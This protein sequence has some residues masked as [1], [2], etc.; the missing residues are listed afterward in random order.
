MGGKMTTLQHSRSRSQFRAAARFQLGAS[1]RQGVIALTAGF[2]LA[3]AVMAGPNGSGATSGSALSSTGPVRPTGCAGNQPPVAMAG[4]DRTESASVELAF[5]GGNSHDPNGSII[6][7][8]WDFGDGATS[9][10]AV[11]YHAFEDG[12]D[13]EVTLVVTDNCGAV[14]S[15]SLIVSIPIGVA[16]DSSC[17]N[18]ITPTA[19]AGSNQQGSTGVAVTLNGSASYDPDGA[20]TSYWWNYGD[21]QFTGW[22]P[23]AIIT[24]TYANA[25]TY[26]V[27]LWARDNCLV[28]SPSD[29]ITVTISSNNA[30]SGNTPPT[31][32]AGSDASVLVNQSISFNGSGST[33][34]GGSISSYSWNF[35]DGTT[36]S[37][38]AATKSYAAAGTYTV[39]LTVTDNCGA[40]SSDTASVSVSAGGGGSCSNNQTPTA[41]AGSD[42]SNSPGA[43]VTLSGTGST[44]PNNNITEYWWNFGDGQYTNWQPLATVSH[45]YASAG[46]FSARLWV[47]DAC[48]AMSASDTAII[49][50]SSGGG[51]NPCA[52]NTPPT[53]NAGADAT[54]TAGVAVSMSGVAS[55]DA[56]GTISSY[57]WNF[58]DST[59]GSGV[60]VSHVYAIAGTY[61]ATLTV[62]DNCAATHSD[63]KVI[64]VS[65]ANPCSNNTAPFAN[66]GADQNGNTG[67]VLTFSAAGSSDLT[68]TITSYAWNFGDGST[69][70]GL[71]ATHAFTTAGTFS[72]RLTVTDSCGAVDD[73]TAIVTV[74][75]PDPCANN[76][77]PVANAGADRTIN[78]GQ[79]ITFTGS[80]TDANGTI[81]HY[82]WNF[83]NGQSTNWQT[84]PTATATYIT[85]GSFTASLW[86]KDNCGASSVADTAIVTVNST[87]PCAG[88][89]PPT[90][91]AGPDRSVQTGTA[92]SF[93]GSGSTDANGTISSYSWNFGDGSTASGVS[94][95][96]S[97]AAAG[98]FTVSLTV[99]DSCNATH[100]DSAVVTVTAPNTGS[101]NADYRV[102]RL[103]STN[104]ISGDEQWQLVNVPT[105][106]VHEGTMLKFDASTSTGPVSFVSW[107]FGDGGFEVGEVVYHLYDGTGSFNA[108]LTVF[109]PAWVA[110]DSLIKTITIT[111][112][113]QFMDALGLAD[114]SSMDIAVWGSYAY[115]THSTGL[116]TTINITSPTNLQIASAI[117]APIGRA[118]A[119]SN[120]Y[121]YVGASSLGLSTYTAVA[122]PVLV[123]TYNTNT[124]DGQSVRD[125]MAAGKVVYM[126]AGPAGLKIMNMSNPASPV[127]L[128]S[129]LLPNSA[130]AE[131]IHVAGGRAYIADTSMKVHIYDVSMINVDAPMAGS[132][133]LLSTISLSWN[134]HQLALAGTT[135]V[136]QA[137]PGGMHLYDISNVSSPV[138]LT[139]YDFSSDAGGLSP[140]GILAVGNTLYATMGQ[141]IGIGTS[142]ARVSLADPAEPYIMEWLSLN[143]QVAGINRG[144]FLHNGILYMANSKYKAVAVDVP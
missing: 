141:V 100:T 70:G 104:P 91:N 107:M 12:G 27:R 93:S 31:A 95:S 60:S 63:T 30:C 121:V 82:W 24:H 140:G 122:T 15:D 3:G 47:R 112:A 71:T 96:H 67:A 29:Q 23:N 59:T 134:V 37:G 89:T 39:T 26:T 128:A 144:P 97:Y 56:N 127:V 84:S 130:T 99:T 41:N 2:A 125:L 94:S 62:T 54:G 42:S 81:T 72:V 22:Q 50:I 85:S 142:V 79:S 80:G 129:R 55:T 110:P 118:I 1:L 46:T 117:T 40:T 35:G 9:S 138:F 7:Y 53:A 75:A 10:G 34:A 19:E 115:T 57:S 131:V 17:D 14:S 120:G 44:D 124:T 48:G 64:T 66:A 73:D 108:E 92:V 78:A 116:L 21:G 43:A 90:A 133:I 86:V 98:T 51:T 13:Y 101:V 68:G 76:V 16:G 33:D 123:N 103:V 52:G 126:A 4:N 136:A 83:G 69:G 114:D 61:T 139:N 74:S 6:A 28:Y 38:V 5:D 36:A 11:A 119:T 102:Y 88:N 137:N 77:L 105:E 65:P 8:S 111:T 113:M 143:S 32:S 132:P 87:N 45:V 49:T 18:N 109:D 58:G 25:G 20:V 135:L 106:I